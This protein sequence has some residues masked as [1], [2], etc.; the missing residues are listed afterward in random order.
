MSQLLPGFPCCSNF[1][2]LINST[3][4]LN[5]IFTKPSSDNYYTDIGL[6]MLKWLISIYIKRNDELEMSVKEIL[7]SYEVKSCLI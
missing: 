5:I 7:E 4:K 6:C 3:I 1:N 2:W